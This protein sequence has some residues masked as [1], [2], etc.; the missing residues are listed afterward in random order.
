[1]SALAFRRVRGIAYE[2]ESFER[3]ES[4]LD[5]TRDDRDIDLSCCD[6]LR[7]GEWLLVSFVVGAESTAVAGRVVDRGDGPRL[8]FEDRDWSRLSDFAEG[9]GPPSRPPESRQ[10]IPVALH[11]PPGAH[12]LVVDDDPG[13]QNVLCCL[14]RA[15]GFG[16]QAVASAEEAF[17]KLREEPADVLVLDWN[18]PGM[19]GVEFCKRLRKDRTLGRLPVL[20][21]TAHTSAG[22]VVQAFE[23]GADDFVSKPFRAP[24]LGARVFSLLRRAR[25]TSEPARV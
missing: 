1:M 5:T 21:V 10:S 24:E 7:E 11:A 14:L 15:S 9:L 3:L 18:L 6:G 25:M 16:V 2:F 8:S 23:A 12:V 20:F 17:D 22:D 13:V 4:L 19:S